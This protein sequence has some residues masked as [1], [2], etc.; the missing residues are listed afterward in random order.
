MSCECMSMLIHHTLYLVM[1]PKWEDKEGVPISAIIFGGRR[2]N[3][4][5]LVYQSRKNTSCCYHY[6]YHQR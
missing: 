1:D 4:V 6:H 2:S 3:T 5:P